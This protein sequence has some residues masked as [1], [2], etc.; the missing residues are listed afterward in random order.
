M[1]LSGGESFIFYPNH[2]NQDRECRYNQEDKRKSEPQ[3]IQDDHPI[4]CFVITR[5]RQPQPN[6]TNG[7][8]D[9]T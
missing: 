2:R 4:E 1:K 3:L 7:R 6:R 9:Q 5:P 8:S